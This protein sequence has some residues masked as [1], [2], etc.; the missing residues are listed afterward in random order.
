M[1]KATPNRAAEPIRLEALTPSGIYRT[2]PSHVTWVNPSETL[3]VV[4]GEPIIFMGRVGI[5]KLAIYPLRVGT[6]VLDWIADF[7]LDPDLAANILQGDVIYWDTGL[8]DADHT[9]KATNVAPAAGFILGYAN[10]PDVRSEDVNLD[11]GDPIAAVPG[12][13]YVRVCSMPMATTAFP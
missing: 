13:T 6:L 8:A 7:V 4:P 12:D 2:E 9:G 3:T 10:L 5:S 1:G 11:A